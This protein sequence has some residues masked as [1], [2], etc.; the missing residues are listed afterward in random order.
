[1]QTFRV[2]YRTYDY[3]RQSGLNIN[4]RVL[5]LNKFYFQ[6]WKSFQEFDFKKIHHF[7]KAAKEYRKHLHQK[8]MEMERERQERAV[9]MEK[10][11]R[12]AYKELEMKLDSANTEL[13]RQIDYRNTLSDQIR[14]NQKVLVSSSCNLYLNKYDT[15][16]LLHL[17]NVSFRAKTVPTIL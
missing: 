7:Q 8:I 10:V 1:M 6:G 15:K 16:I 9:K 2:L 13:Q 5:Q 11:K 14:N 17:N 12:G 4:I 3:S